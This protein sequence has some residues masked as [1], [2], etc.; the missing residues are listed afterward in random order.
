MK[1]KN[2]RALVVDDEMLVRD[3]TVR[4][5]S[6]AGFVCE[7]APDGAEAM[8]RLKE[9]NFDLLITDLRM[10]G[11]NGYRL[12]IDA[13][14]LDPRPFIVVLTGVAEPRIAQDLLLRGVE[15]IVFKPVSYDV[16]AAKVKALMT[17]CQQRSGRAASFEDEAKSEQQRKITLVELGKKISEVSQIFPIS[18]AALDVFNMTST[19]SGDA[20]QITELIECDASLCA[21]ILKVVNSSYYNRSGQPISSIKTAVIRVGQRQIGELALAHNALAA[22]AKSHFTWLDAHLSWKRSLAAGVAMERLVAAGHHDEIEGGLHNAAIMHP[23]GR[24]VLGTLFPNQYESMIG[25]CGE[26]NSCLRTEEQKIFPVP[27]GHVLTNV[28]QSWGIPT[29][30]TRPLTQL[31]ASYAAIEQLS[32]PERTRTLLLKVAVHFARLAVGRW[33]P[34]DMVEIPPDD[35]LRSLAVTDVADLVKQISEDLDTLCKSG[36]GSVPTPRAT[37]EAEPDPLDRLGF[38]NAVGGSF[39]TIQMLLTR[40]GWRVD[41]VSDPQTLRDRPLVLNC[42]GAAGSQ[43]PSWVRELPSEQCVIVTDHQHAGE[44]SDFQRVVAL[45]ASVKQLEQCLHADVRQAEPVPA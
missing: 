37:A 45:P 16:L 13:L 14:E 3:L 7:D 40:M 39:S 22:L 20:G 42:I 26:S 32:E 44:Y 18:Q 28:L 25:R 24:I 21:Q 12:A 11:Q 6:A 43:L 1:G 10:P 15:D 34:W 4:A 29:R 35:V 17:R 38:C 5:L 23:L 19:G 41:V 27:H 30:S 36:I 33:E 2:L 9:K 31:H 8:V